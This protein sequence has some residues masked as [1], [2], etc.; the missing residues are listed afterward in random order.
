[1]NHA[2]SENIEDYKKKKEL[3]SLGIPTILG[4]GTYKKKIQYIVMPIFRSDVFELFL[5]NDRKMPM[6]TIFR[7]AIQLLNALEY[8]HACKYVHADVTGSN[9][10]VDDNG[11]AY[12]IDFQSALPYAIGKYEENPEIQHHGTVE[13]CS[14]DAHLVNTLS[15]EFIQVQTYVLII[16]NVTGYSYNERRFG[17]VGI[18]FVSVV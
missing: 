9:I 11:M 13:Y 16:N 7:L 5:K 10:M 18:Q 8:V 17:D 2:S 14:Y 6:H 12:L 4:H 3:T 1:M 15:Y